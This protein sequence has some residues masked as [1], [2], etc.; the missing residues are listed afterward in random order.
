MDSEW[1]LHRA[2]HDSHNQFVYFLLGAVGAAI[3]LAVNQTRG[4]ELSWSQVPLAV[5]VILW[6][7]SF[8]FGC[9]NRMWASLSLNTNARLYEV[10]DGRSEIVG[11]HPENIDQG[12]RVVRESFERQSDKA[13]RAYALQF[14]LLVV[15]SLFY[16]AWHVLEMYMRTIGG[17][18]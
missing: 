11:S 6:G 15:G 17:A 5:A 14:G 13:K 2:L 3:A 10:A 12:I 1:E 18:V 7:L 4:L 16:L 8:F 9:R